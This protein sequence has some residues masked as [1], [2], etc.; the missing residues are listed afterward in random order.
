MGL[1]VT[2]TENAKLKLHGL[3]IELPSVYIRI[4]PYFHFNGIDIESDLKHFESK[5][6][7]KQDTDQTPLNINALFKGSNGDYGLIFNHACKCVGEETQCHLTYH[8]YLKQ[9]LEALGYTVTIDL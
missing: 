5:E 9:A 3:S 6:K 4:K 2:S 8:T 7:Y 1:I